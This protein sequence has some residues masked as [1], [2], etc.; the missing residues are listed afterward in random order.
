VKEVLVREPFEKPKLE[1]ALATLRAENGKNQELFHQV[2]VEAAT[3][4]TPEGRRELSTWFEGEK[5]RRF[6]R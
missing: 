4:A 3:S 5:G 1:G 6:R 2:L